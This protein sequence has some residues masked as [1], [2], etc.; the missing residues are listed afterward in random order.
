MSNEKD[1]YIEAPSPSP[2][3]FT[4]FSLQVMSENSA[5]PLPPSYFFFLLKHIITNKICT[6]A[7]ALRPKGCFA[8]HCG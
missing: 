7:T 5:N 2:P 1:N 3:F 6:F 4:T 8:G